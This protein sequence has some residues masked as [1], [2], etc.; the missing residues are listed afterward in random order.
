MIEEKENNQ[1]VAEKSPDYPS[2]LLGI[3]TI[4]AGNEEEKREFIKYRLEEL[5]KNAKEGQLSH[6]GSGIHS[7]FLGPRMEV[8]RSML[9]DPIVMDDPNLYKD[10]F[11]TI[12][13][14]KSSEQWQGKSLREII[15]N[16]IQWALTKYF[17]NICAGP[18]TESENREFY[19]D[20]VSAESGPISIG[21]FKGKGFAVCAEKGA[22]A[23]NLL[24]FVGLESDLI[25]SAKC[26]I[27]AESAEN[28]H[29]FIVLHS[30]SGEI[31]YDPANPKLLLD[32]KDDIVSYGPAF[33]RITQEQSQEL[34]AGGKIEVLHSDTKNEGNSK[35]TEET[36]KRIYAGPKKS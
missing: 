33:Y 5:S 17:G 8:C 32:D 14:F 30:P 35:L 21:E 7:G 10:L 23:Q 4:L 25:A 6:I 3:E 13:K 11:S 2:T 18:S 29:Y 20:H 22:A 26:K 12:D 24:A 1:E 27:P 28:A 31:I 9:V 34:L 36:Q 16:A 15:P 19:A